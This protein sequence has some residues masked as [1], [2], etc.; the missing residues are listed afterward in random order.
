MAVP[1]SAAWIAGHSPRRSKSWSAT[2]TFDPGLGGAQII[3]YLGH[4]RGGVDQA[5]VRS[6]SRA[7]R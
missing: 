2:F 3:E 1:R 4:L 6:F 7:E 5:Y